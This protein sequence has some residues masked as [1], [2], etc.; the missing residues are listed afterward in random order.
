M[1]K[2][3]NLHELE[4][5]I[6]WK[7]LHDQLLILRFILVSLYKTGELIKPIIVTNFQKLNTEIF[8]GL[9]ML[10]ETCLSH[11]RL[12]NDLV[13]P[14]RIIALIGK[15]SKG[16]IQNSFSRWYHTWI[17]IGQLYN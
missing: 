10:I 3:W 9:I 5:T 11:L 4:I 17:F 12:C 2:Y 6:S 1:K 13:N 7:T 8:L 15:N 14:G 16:R